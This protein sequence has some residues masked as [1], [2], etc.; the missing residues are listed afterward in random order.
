MIGTG[1]VSLVLPPEE[2]GFTEPVLGE[3]TAKHTNEEVLIQDDEVIICRNYSG[4]DRSL[5][6]LPG[7]RL[8]Y[9]TPPCHSKKAKNLSTLTHD[10]GFLFELTFSFLRQSQSNCKSNSALI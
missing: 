5:R 3:L 6:R 2:I 9:H 1:D 8:S 10:P 4:E 7:P